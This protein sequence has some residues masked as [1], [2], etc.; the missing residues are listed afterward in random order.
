MSNFYC[1]KCGVAVTEGKDGRYVTGCEHYPADVKENETIKLLEEY[2]RW[3]ES[4][5]YIDS[6]WW[7]EEP[8]AI[9]QFMEERKNA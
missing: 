8:G 5:W 6:D 3:L 1:E 2:S 7:S 9:Q 4:H